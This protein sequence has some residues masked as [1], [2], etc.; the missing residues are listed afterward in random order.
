MSDACEKSC[1]QLAVARGRISVLEERVTGL[2]IERQEM[3]EQIA[4]LE[5]IG[6][7]ATLAKRVADWDD[8]S[9]RARKLSGLMSRCST[10]LAGALNALQVMGAPRQR[11]RASQSS[12]RGPLWTRP[13]IRDRLRLAWVAL[14][15]RSSD[16]VQCVAEMVAYSPEV[17]RAF[18]EAYRVLEEDVEKAREILTALEDA[19]GMSEPRVVEL[20]S[21]VEVEMPLDDDD[22]GAACGS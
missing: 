13:R 4:L 19:L 18:D 11:L 9:R 21:W 3:V 17:R 10:W 5:S 7:N 16:E 15:S 22:G 14:A 6:D 8:R 2:E 12:G 1:Y 20:R